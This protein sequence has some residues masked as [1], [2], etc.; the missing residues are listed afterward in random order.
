LKRKHQSYGDTFY[1][2]EVFVEISD[3][4]HYLCRAIDQDGEIH[5]AKQYENNRAEQS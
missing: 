2:D 3:K 1:I 4:Q 5:G